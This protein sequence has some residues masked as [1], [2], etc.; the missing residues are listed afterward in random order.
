[1]NLRQTCARRGCGHDRDTHY[2]EL[3][4]FEA[5]GQ[6]VW[7]K[8]WRRCN[9]MWCECWRFKPEKDESR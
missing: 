9:G 8:V 2:S 1:M 5:N 7:R 4:P 3:E 6:Q